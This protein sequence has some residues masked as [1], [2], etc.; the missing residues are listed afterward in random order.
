MQKFFFY[1]WK[2]SKIPKVPSFA[3]CWDAFF[4]L[5]F[6]QR[7]DLYQG[8]PCACNFKMPKLLFLAVEKAN[9]A[10]LKPVLKTSQVGPNS[11]FTYLKERVRCDLKRLKNRLLIRTCRD[12][13]NQGARVSLSDGQWSACEECQKQDLLLPREKAFHCTVL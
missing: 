11:L 2:N 13:S 10:T 7:G 5:N 9:L 3:C 12:N 1:Y 4:S 8:C 6:S